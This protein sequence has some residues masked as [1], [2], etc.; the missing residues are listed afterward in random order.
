MLYG[1]MNH[2]GLSVFKEIEWAAENG[3]DFLDLTVEPPMMFHPETDAGKVSELLRERGLGIVGHTAFFLPFNSPFES[4]R[5]AAVSVIRQVGQF[6]KTAGSET[7]NVHI[8]DRPAARHIPVEDN[9]SYLEDSFRKMLAVADE[10]G[11]KLMVEHINGS[12]ETIE[13]LD[14]LFDKFPNLF[15]HLDVGHANLRKGENRTKEFLERYGSRLLH[16][17]FSDNKGE[18]D[19]H[20]PLGAGTIDWEE[21]TN[22]LKAHGYNGTIT[23][24]VF[25]PDRELVLFS[26]RKIRKLFE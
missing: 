14:L 4:V 25:S 17:H 21:I 16:I 23:F 15:F 26:R 8:D 12:E 19:D 20:L 24:E 9:F 5:D 6:L 11:L 22:I 18:R 7:M 3:F 1:I 2:P 10:L 13:I